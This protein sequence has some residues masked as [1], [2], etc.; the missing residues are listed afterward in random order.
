M[1]DAPGHGES[2]IAEDGIEIISNPT[3][4][5]HLMLVAERKFGDLGLR[6]LSSTSFASWWTVESDRAPPRPHL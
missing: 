2:P 3:T 4:L 6:Q 5:A 1:D